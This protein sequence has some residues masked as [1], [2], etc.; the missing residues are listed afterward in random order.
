MADPVLVAVEGSDEIPRRFTAAPSVPAFEPVVRAV[1]ADP[2][3]LTA[4]AP[5]DDVALWS[6]HELF[7]SAAGDGPAEA[8]ARKHA[9]PEGVPDVP[10]PS[11]L[12]A[13]TSSDA[14]DGCV[15]QLVA[16]LA[17]VGTPGDASAVEHVEA[18]VGSSADPMP[19][20]DPANAANACASAFARTRESEAVTLVRLVSAFAAGPD[21]VGVDPSGA[22]GLGC[23]A[24]APV[25]T[26]ARVPGP[27][28]EV[29]PRATDPG[30]ALFE[31]DAAT[32]W[33]DATVAGPAPPGV[34]DA[35]PPTAEPC[36]SG[37]T[38]GWADSAGPSASA[39]SA[40][41][42]SSAI[43]ATSSRIFLIFRTKPPHVPRRERDR[44]S[45]P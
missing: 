19:A 11:E 22:D 5:A 23:D 15:P 34:A 7:R 17:P 28:A 45:R 32:G 10:L 39:W 43:T 8:P 35:D 9:E 18:R 33:L 4:D 30:A 2:V 6:L 37:R 40:V 29:E 36:G 13:A 20:T 44:G 14:D 38:S 3:A 31:L 41:T 24:D 42:L 16:R 21:V 27:L 1:F 25:G 12:F 26:F